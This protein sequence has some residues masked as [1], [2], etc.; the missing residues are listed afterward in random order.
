[1]ILVAL[2]VLL[3][4]GLFIAQFVVIRRSK[5]LT[6][7]QGDISRIKETE[8]KAQ[9]D[10]VDTELATQRERAALAE[11]SLI[12]LRNESQPRRLTG[13]Q[14]DKLRDLLIGL[15]TPIAVVSRMLD[16]ESMDFADDF[17]EVLGTA[18]WET[19]RIKTLLSRKYGLL[20]GTTS[21]ELNAA[22]PVKLLDK[23]LTEIGVP[24]GVAVFTAGDLSMTPHIEINVL[25]LLV[26]G[27]PPPPTPR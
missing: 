12:K 13:T 11:A 19:A 20:I 9:Q 24:H 15:P 21:S 16:T 14:K 18:H 23:A 4:A 17:A 3:A 10:R 6:D 27:H 2:T 26:E 1:V 22:P 25:Y 8:A 7:L 5:Q